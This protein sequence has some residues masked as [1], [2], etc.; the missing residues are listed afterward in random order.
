MKAVLTLAIMLFVNQFSVAGATEDLWKALKETN[1]PNAL[2]AIAAGADVNSIDPAFGTPLNFAACWA[3]A[4]V[5]K[6]LLDAK[7][8]VHFVAPANGYT[9]MLNAAYWGNTEV[10]KLLLAAGSDVKIKNK[11]GQPFL[12]VVL[13][14]GNANMEI[15]K[16]VVDAGADPNEKYQIMTIKDLTMMNALI[17]AKDPKEKVAY[18]QTISGVMSK[19]GVTFPERLKN[20]KE[21]DFTP[22]GDYANYLLEKGAD[23]NQ[24]MG[25]AFGSILFQ[26]T[27][28][29]RTGIVLALIDAK[30]DLNVMGMIKGSE[31]RFFKVTSLMVASLKGNNELVEAFCKAGA[32][33]NFISTEIG[34]QQISTKDLGDRTYTVYTTPSNKNTAVSFAND[35]NHPDTVEL[36][37]KYGGKG[38]KEIKKK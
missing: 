32:D 10:F 38:P 33:V 20:A 24:I 12:A 35:N 4:A 34:N 13:F 23:P 18:M 29:G 11:I 21:S 36:L 26:A 2:A 15:I 9:P 8:D 7:S 1:Y 22:L 16:M 19:M 6:A 3:D 30:A 28:L 25:G 37:R 27:D 17:G 31:Q 5:V 14:A